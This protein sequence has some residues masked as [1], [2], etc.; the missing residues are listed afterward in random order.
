MPTPKHGSGWLQNEIL[1]I[2]ESITT[3]EIDLPEGKLATPHVL[4]KIVAARRGEDAPSTGAVAAV[5]HRWRDLGFIN[6]HAKPFAFKAFS[7]AGQTHGLAGL[8]TKRRAARSAE[9][10]KAKGD[11]PAKP[12]AAKKAAK[13]KASK[14]KA[15][16][17]DTAEAA[18]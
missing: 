10:T 5:L 3:G 9:R 6:V 4:A 7:A 8:Q 11:A 17:K 13:P 16:K 1:E 14:P 15:A 18:A 12:K 2:V